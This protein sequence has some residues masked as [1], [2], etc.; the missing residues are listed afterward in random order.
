MSTIKVYKVEAPSVL[1]RYFTTLQVGVHNFT[2]FVDKFSM[3]FA[4]KEALPQNLV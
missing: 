3:L 2:F 1:Q 4:E